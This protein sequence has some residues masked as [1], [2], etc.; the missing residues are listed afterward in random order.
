MTIREW[1]ERM[2]TVTKTNRFT[3]ALTHWGER[4]PG[5][6]GITTESKYERKI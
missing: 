1:S 3:I 5:P 2:R 4:E 6:L